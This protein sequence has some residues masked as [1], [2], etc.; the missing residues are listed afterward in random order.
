METKIDNFSQTLTKLESQRQKNVNKINRV[1][2]N[3]LNTTKQVMHFQSIINYL[4]QQEFND[5]IIV[6]GLTN[7]Q[8][9]P[10]EVI[11]KIFQIFDTHTNVLQF[12]SHSHRSYISNEEQKKLEI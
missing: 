3:T 11:Q 2:L 4:E 10:E 9:L 5:D 7:L 1:D 6:T 12:I 8:V